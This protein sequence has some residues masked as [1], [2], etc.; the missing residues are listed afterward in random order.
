[1]S[2]I[3]QKLLGTE[4]GRSQS[5][6]EAMVDLLL[7]GIYSDNLISLAENAFIEQ[8][9][10]QLAWESGISFNGYLQRVIPK[11]RAVK[12][13]PAKE[14][15]FLL[16]ITERLGNAAAKQKALDQLNAL[17]AADGIVQLEEAFMAQVET[18]LK[19]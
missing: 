15:E 13:N 18:A 4:A 10:Q 12:G 19:L 6:T 9:S 11:V 5:Q 2:N 17:L 3:F 8:E 7:L 1:M 14:A 16:E